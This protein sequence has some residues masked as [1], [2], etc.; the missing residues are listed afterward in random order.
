[1][2]TVCTVWPEILA[3]RYFGGLLK[4]WHL[5]EFTLAVV[6]VLYIMIFIAKWLIER[7][8]NLTGPWATFGSVRTKLM[9]K[10][11]WRVYK[12]LLYLIWTV[13]V[14]ILS[15]GF[16]I[17][18]TAIFR[19]AF[20]WRLV[21]CF[22]E[23][24]RT[25]LT[26]KRLLHLVQCLWDPCFCCNDFVSLPKE[27]NLRRRPNVACWGPIL[28]SKRRVNDDVKRAKL[29]TPDIYTMSH[30]YRIQWWMFL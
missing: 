21:R 19:R 5:A 3:G 16:R 26:A 6:Q 30:W 27:E 13:F 28:V 24:I 8:G 14:W 15:C 9:I 4:L 1:M 29:E 18:T 23:A 10:C 12:S 22:L 25:R 20:Y 2:C 7:A 17:W 11:N